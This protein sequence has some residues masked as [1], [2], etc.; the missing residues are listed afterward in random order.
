MVLCNLSEIKSSVSNDLNPHEHN[1]WKRLVHSVTF[2]QH[3]SIV[4]FDHQQVENVS[5]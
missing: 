1:I 5:A 3:F 2:L 4:P